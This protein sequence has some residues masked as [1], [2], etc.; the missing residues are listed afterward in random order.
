MSSHGSNPWYE[1]VGVVSPPIVI[2]IVKIVAVDASGGPVP[3]PVEGDAWAA[4]A[5]IVIVFNKWTS[6]DGSKLIKV[7]LHVAKVQDASS[8]PVIDHVGNLLKAFGVAS[9]ITC[10]ESTA[11]EEV[12]VDEFVKKC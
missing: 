4:G 10:F 7:C 8:C 5:V 11:D 12:A 9:A 3:A 2:I 1:L 6:L